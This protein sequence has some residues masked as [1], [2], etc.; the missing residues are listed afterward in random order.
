MDLVAKGVLGLYI[1]K[2]L[3]IE[4]HF[5]ISKTSLWNMNIKLFA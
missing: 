4:L 2:L 3:K 5:V 1:Y